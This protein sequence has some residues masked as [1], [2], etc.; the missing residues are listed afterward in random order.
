[1]QARPGNPFDS[2][3]HLFEIKWDGT[4]VLA[5]VEADGYRLVNRRKV[6]LTERY[7]EMEC[8]RELPP[9]VVLDGEMV[10]MHEGRPD[11]ARLMTREQ[12]RSPLKIRTSARTLPATFI[13]F[14]QL[15]GNYAAIM[16][17]PLLQRRQRLVE[18]LAPC[19]SPRLALSEG[20]TGPGETYFRHIVEQGLEGVVAK[21]LSSKYH[22]GQRTDAWIK[23]KRRSR[24]LC[25]VVGFEPSGDDDF[26]SLLLAAD[27]GAGL[28]FIGKVGGGFN[29]S[30]R[31]TLNSILWTT[32]C[33]SPLVDCQR[34]ATWVRPTLYCWVSYLEQT[35]RGEL[36]SPVFEELLPESRQD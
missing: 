32:V 15:Y 25:V 18:T 29:E 22:P 13:A 31:S 7:P 11:F 1:M 28:K 23:I 4:R 30:L 10:V 17:E 3:E 35:A 36:R 20:I 34:R 33:N 14:D 5:F 9:G 12:A 27:Q 6:D 21:R 24:I 16:S 8:L 26:R 19:R 2:S